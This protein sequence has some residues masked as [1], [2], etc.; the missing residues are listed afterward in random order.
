MAIALICRTPLLNWPN[1]CFGVEREVVEKFNIQETPVPRFKSLSTANREKA[2]C[3]FAELAGGESPERWRN[4]DEWVGSLFDLTPDDV[5]TISD[6]LAYGLPFGDNKEAARAPTVVAS[7]EFFANRLNCELTPWAERFGRKLA[8][9][10]VA[11]P[12]LS[13]WQFVAITAGVKKV[14][15]VDTALLQ[16]MQ[17]TA[18]TLSSSEIIYRDEQSDCLF[19]GRLNQARYW[20]ISQARLVARRLIWEHVD[21]LSGKLAG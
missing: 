2:A 20:S 11:S 17:Q 6:T 8:V 5:Q 3:L 13:P 21:F 1:T 16:A 4:T 19:V 10:L 14:G 7:R 9:C 18:D 15:Q 12:A